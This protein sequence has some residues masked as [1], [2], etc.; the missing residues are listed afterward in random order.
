M[1][2]P[3]Y[4]LSTLLL[5]VT[6]GQPS[7]SLAL[8][9][10]WKELSWTSKADTTVTFDADFL[11]NRPISS[12]PYYFICHKLY[13][14]F[15]EFPMIWMGWWRGGGLWCAYGCRGC[16][17]R[18]GLPWQGRRQLP[19]SRLIALCHPP[20]SP[21]PVSDKHYLKV[22]TVTF[23]AD[24]LLWLSIRHWT[25]VCCDVSSSRFDPDTR[26]GLLQ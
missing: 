23:D 10:W 17:C 24:S 26:S 21:A 15:R 18:R 3:T 25:V 14:M 1:A 4:S 13:W 9:E 20:F 5:T 19:A 8:G 7:F 16:P 12:L 2:L 22:I 6:L 11:Q